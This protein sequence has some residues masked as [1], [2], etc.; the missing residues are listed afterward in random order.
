MSIHINWGSLGEL[1]VALTV[2]IKY[3]ESA[4]RDYREFK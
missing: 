3:R 2:R 1:S 4:Y